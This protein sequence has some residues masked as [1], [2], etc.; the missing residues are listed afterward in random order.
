MNRNK[1]KSSLLLTA[2]LV[3]GVPIL[4]NSLHTVFQSD[5]RTNIGWLLLIPVIVGLAYFGTVNIPG[6]RASISI[7]DTVI[8]AAVILFGVHPAVILAAADAL[9]HT[10]KSNRR[11][12]THAY[13]VTISAIAIFISV[14]FVNYLFP[15]VLGNSDL[16]FKA[17]QII[18]PL[19][20]MA[21]LYYCS[22]Y[23]LLTLMMAV[24]EHKNV[25]KIWKN[26]FQMV[27]LGYLANTS[28]AGIVCLLI[29]YVQFY[30]ILIAAP[31]IAV[32]FFTYKVY[33][34]KVEDSNKHLTEL[35]SLYDQVSHAKAEWESTFNAMS[36]VILM[37]DTEGKL[38]R[39]NNAGLV[40]EKAD[41]FEKLEHAH[42]CD[43]GITCEE[44]ICRV[45]E[46]LS[47]GK[48][49]ISEVER[50]DRTFM[51]TADPLLND[52]GDI[53]G[54][55][56]ILKDITEQK[57]LR[58]QLMQS[59]KMS[60]IGQ[61]VSGVA[62]ELN[63]PLTSIIGYSEMAQMD[64][65][66]CI[67]TRK[68]LDTVVHESMRARKIVQN[69][70]TFARQ[71]K[72]EKILTDVRSV[73]ERVVELRAYEM[74]VHSINVETD[75]HEL[76]VIMCDGPQLQQVFLN[77]II[78]AEHAML[79]ANGRGNL[80][81]KAN[82]VDEQIVV[83][84]KD[85]GPGIPA[86]NIT[87]IFD[88]F[89]TTK[90]VG[91]GTGLGL[92]ICYGIVQE[93]GGKLRVSSKPGQGATFTI[94]LPA[95]TVAS[96]AAETEAETVLPSLSPRN[97]LVVDDEEF[98]S[99]IVRGVLEREGH[100]VI[101]ASNGA[102]A[103]S[104]LDSGDYDLILS[105]IK[106]PE[107]SGYALYEE[108]RNRDKELANRMI[109]MTGDMVNNETNEFLQRTGNQYIPKPFAVDE[110]LRSVNSATYHAA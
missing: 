76:P 14:S 22:N 102:A 30:V 87:K 77:I 23:T 68:Q 21:L 27:L 75:I 7:S 103:L 38:N 72:P 110:L 52:Q 39:I 109:F 34:D 44:G 31:I 11:A 8:I 73:L 57:R 61:L 46:T 13:N 53:Q 20:V 80:I 51:I 65:Q 2:A 15:N 35:S 1:F 99:E 84:I 90:E 78:N 86:E 37:F 33:R 59:E 100:R 89:F 79:N 107:L 45:K 81:V 96:E 10:L 88:P 64:D 32:I 91:K 6:A 85:N 48:Q 63:N 9:T 17:S 41:S 18:A 19:S 12:S 101:T 36:D 40:C 62:H 58:E 104:L 26:T 70:L 47:T 82:L 67:E 69:L 42:C 54:I 97:I 108:V 5:F 71:H 3:V 98:I 106:M 83:T 25:F 56:F 105:D 16:N 93:H 24:R 55:V 60:A 74:K 43:L 4:A 95:I 28:T 29:K 50:Y 94:E 92:S 66:L 49:S